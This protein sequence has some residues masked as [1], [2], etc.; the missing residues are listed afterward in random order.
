MI[1]IVNYVVSQN[2]LFWRVSISFNVLMSEIL[3]PIISFRLHMWY[4]PQYVIAHVWQFLCVE[5][6]FGTNYLF[7][8]S[9][10]MLKIY[11]LKCP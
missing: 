2:Y 3:Y 10:N 9:K 11:Y 1:S 4:P 5:N 7:S 8:G 6:D